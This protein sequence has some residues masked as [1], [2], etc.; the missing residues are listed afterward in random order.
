MTQNS[1]KRSWIGGCK[2]CQTIVNVAGVAVTL[3][4]G[5]IALSIDKEIQNRSNKEF[6]MERSMSLFQGY[7]N[8]G[9]YR[10]FA[11]HIWYYLA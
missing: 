6:R 4:I 7:N 8:N 1:T 5:F 11:T 10:E 3:F 2:E 9:V